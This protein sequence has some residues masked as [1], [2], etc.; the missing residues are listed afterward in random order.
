MLL[1]TAVYASDADPG[2]LGTILFW[3]F[4]TITSLVPDKLILISSWEI[5][6]RNVHACH[7]VDSWRIIHIS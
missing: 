7:H 3:Y 6:G 5:M 4:N 1:E 2:S